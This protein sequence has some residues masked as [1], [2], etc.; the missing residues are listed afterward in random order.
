MEAEK[1]GWFGEGGRKVSGMIKVLDFDSGGNH[2]SL[3]N[4]QNP[5]N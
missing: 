1:G 3:Y 4:S 5:L 2:M